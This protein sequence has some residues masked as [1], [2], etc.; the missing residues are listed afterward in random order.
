MSLIYDPEIES[1][2]VRELNHGTFK[3]RLPK[4]RA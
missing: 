4:R 1:I 2:F 3:L